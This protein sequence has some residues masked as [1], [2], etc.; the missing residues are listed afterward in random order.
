MPSSLTSRHCRPCNNKHRPTRLAVDTP[1]GANDPA[2][3]YSRTFMLMNRFNSLGVPLKLGRSAAI[4]RPDTMLVL[5]GD[6]TCD[7]S[8][9]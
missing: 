2:A 9:D 4:E 3:Q 5:I 1:L 8:S 7:G 6:V